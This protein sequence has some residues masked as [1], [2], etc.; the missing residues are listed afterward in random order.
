MESN[1]NINNDQ[2]QT[3]T[4]PQPVA[5]TKTPIF[6]KWWF[7]VIIGVVIIGIGAGAGTAGSDNS[8]DQ[9]SG[10][11]TPSGN[12]STLGD[13]DVVISNCRLAE[14]YAG[15]PII[16]VTYEFTNNN[17]E[18]TAFWLAISAD[19]YQNGIG[20]NTCY[21]VDDSANYSSDNQ[22]KEIKK[23]AT[24]SV[25]VAYTLNDTTTPVEIEVSE[26][27]SLND[28]KITKTF[29]ID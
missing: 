15:A 2:M 20:L 14:D 22:M 8:G 28:K 5:V 29:T 17:D 24:I 19:A 13:Y 26:I 6:K 9:G 3:S 1:H 10:S 7:W 16:I 4:A 25:E 23:G 27:F 12:S 11:A 18:P 21:V